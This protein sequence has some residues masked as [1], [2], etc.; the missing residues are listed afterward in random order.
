[1][2]IKDFILGYLIGKQ[3][4]GGGASVEPLTVTENG[5]YSEE[6]VAYSPVTVNVP[7][8][9]ANFKTGTFTAGT[10]VNSVDTG[11][12][13]NG[14]PIMCLVTVEGGAYNTA[15]TD[16]YDLVRQNAVG[17]FVFTKSATATAPDYTGSG[18]D[19]CVMATIYKSSAS[20]ATSYSRTSG[21]QNKLLASTNPSDDY[22]ACVKMSNKNTLKYYGTNATGTAGLASGIT[23]RYWIVYSE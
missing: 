1:M 23:Y 2:N 12:S 11:Y 5:E 7:S 16:W 10:G 19:S 6:G 20:S 22:T 9:A 14:Y 13:G 18:N 17:L 15:N 4:G 3:D 8:G 21:M